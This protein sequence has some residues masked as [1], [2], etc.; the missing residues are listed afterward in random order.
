MILG[1]LMAARRCDA[2]VCAETLVSTWRHPA[3]LQVTGYSYYCVASEASMLIARG[4]SVYVRQGYPC[5]RKS[6][7][8][9]RLRIRAKHMN[10]Y[11]FAVHRNPGAD[12]SLLDFL[13]TAMSEMQQADRK[14]SIVFVG[15]FN[16]HHREWLGSVSETD[17]HGRALLDFATSSSCQHLVAGPTHSSGNPLDLVLTDVPGVVSVVVSPPVGR[18]DHS[19]MLLSLNVDQP[20]MDFMVVKEVYVKTGIIWANVAADVESLPWGDCLVMISLLIG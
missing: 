20:V 11:V 3:E 10:F 17:A 12:D 13:L 9:C 4:M 5:V 1:A 16:A 2:M 6:C 14:F 18:S 15:D 8:E 19:S 7:Y